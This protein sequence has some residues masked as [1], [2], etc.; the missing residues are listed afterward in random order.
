MK[1]KKCVDVFYILILCLIES[2]MQVKYLA[3][4]YFD[5]VNFKNL[6]AIFGV[7]ILLGIFIGF[8]PSLLKVTPP[9][10]S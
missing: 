4:S 9:H 1:N 10:V 3:K 5:K 2:T 6:T 7:L 8:I